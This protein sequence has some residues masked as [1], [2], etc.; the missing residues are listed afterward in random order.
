MDLDLNAVKMLVGGL[1]LE[2]LALN[3]EV[4]ACRKSLESLRLLEM[5]PPQKSPVLRDE[6]MGRG[7]SG[8]MGSPRSG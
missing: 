4:A 5:P 8:A 1:I 7:A 3:A 2:N 6:P